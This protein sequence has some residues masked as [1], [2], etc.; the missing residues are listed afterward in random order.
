[1][2]LL[3]A[4]LLFGFQPASN[5]LSGFTISVDIFE[6]SQ[7]AYDPP[8]YASKLRLAGVVSNFVSGDSPACARCAGSRLAAGA[9]PV[10]ESHSR[11]HR[12]RLTQ[13]FKDREFRPLRD[14]RRRFVRHAR[15][16]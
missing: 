4:V 6:T 13:R 1:M 16:T 12:G 3:I 11:G 8:I 10:G 15:A 7:A 14:L 9:S 2:Q 5:D